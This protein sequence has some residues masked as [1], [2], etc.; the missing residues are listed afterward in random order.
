MEVTAV[1]VTT[2]PKESLVLTELMREDPGG[3]VRS[4]I[5]GL[6]VPLW[7]DVVGVTEQVVLVEAS[8]YGWVDTSPAAAEAERSM[9][10]TGCWGAPGFVPSVLT[11][12]LMAEW[13]TKALGALVL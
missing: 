1:E 2:L 10:V 11:D 5:W 12:K 3:R 13:G 9:E 4:R 6:G 8:K 7:S